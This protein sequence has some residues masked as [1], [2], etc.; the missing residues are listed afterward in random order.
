M[1]CPSQIHERSGEP[2]SGTR[3]P[4]IGRRTVPVTIPAPPYGGRLV[5]LLA[6]P[7]RASELK[8]RARKGPSWQLT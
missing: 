2:G 6:P 3:L 1:T 5:D 8:Q 7:D 4:E